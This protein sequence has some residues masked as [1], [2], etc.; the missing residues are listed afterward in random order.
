MENKK[1]RVCFI[2]MKAYPLFVNNTEFIFGGA[3]VQLFQLSKKIAQDENFEV[4]FAVAD[5][6]QKSPEIIENVKVFPTMKLTRKFGFFS[7][8]VS[9]F[10]LIS[11]LIK[12]KS[13]V[14]IQ[15]AIGV[16]TG[17]LALILMIFRKKFIY[18]TANTPDVDGT[19]GKKD[20][21]LRIFFKIGICFASLVIT[22][23][24]EFKDL[25]K[26][27]FKR[28]AYVLRN[29]FKLSNMSSHDLNK[30]KYVLWVANS[31]KIKRPEIFL[32]MARK[33]SKVNFVMIMPKHD[34]KLWEHIHNE[35][36]KIK[37]LTFIESVPFEKVDKYFSE[38]CLFVNTSI[39]EGFP[40]TFVQAV[41]HG[42]PIV[43]LSVNPDN[44]INEYQ[45]GFFA[46]DNLEIIYNQ[47]LKILEKPSEWEV[48]SRNAYEYAKENHDIEKNI[49]KFKKIINNLMKKQ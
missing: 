22:Q 4:S 25:I 24:E 44:F 39:H 19:A 30:R 21:L 2:S 34:L 17:I 38:A 46:D 45:C 40:N 5:Y 26:K 32:E 20:F 9:Q 11:Y 15:R 37:N 33:N 3:E 28:E 29:S 43:S 23:G 31:R 7:G 18:M 10:K 12:N 27:N 14:Y 42:V 1:I 48:F 13:D 8:I 16:E 36:K 41:M 47:S 6:G 49:I 35:S